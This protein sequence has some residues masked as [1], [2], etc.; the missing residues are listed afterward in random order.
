[1]KLV[2]ISDTE[3]A[4]RNISVPE[5]DVL[6][7]AGDVISYGKTEKYGSYENQLK[8]F[9]VWLGEQPHAHKIFI[10]G[11]HDDLLVRKAMNNL[12]PGNYYLENSGVE[13]NGVRFWGS[14]NTVS[15]F[16]MAFEKEESELEEIYSKIPD[17]TDILITHVPPKGILDANFHGKSCGSKSLYNRVLDLNPKVHVFGHVHHSYGVYKGDETTFV[18]ASYMNSENNPIILE[19]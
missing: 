8:D 7:H 10:G 2:L 18:N 12:M 6:I 17:N 1:M 11:N 4:H 14:P 13:I 16:G 15:F 9:V 5:G 3:G 19:I